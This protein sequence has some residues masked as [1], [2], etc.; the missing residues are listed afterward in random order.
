MT[1][2]SRSR[3]DILD[4]LSR[5]FV[6]SELATRASE[7]GR[8]LHERDG[9]IIVPVYDPQL[10]ANLRA[11]IPDV[12]ILDEE[13]IIPALGQASIRYVHQS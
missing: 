2:V 13:S 6:P 1:V 4:F 8:P 3:F 10:I 11:K 12:E 5:R 9:C 7:S